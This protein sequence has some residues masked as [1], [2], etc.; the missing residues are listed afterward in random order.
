MPAVK[1]NRGHL[2]ITPCVQMCAVLR[3]LS[4]TD[5]RR[6]GRYKGDRRGRRVLAGKL[7]QL[8]KALGA[9]LC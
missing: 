7:N 9:R 2:D 4:D 3:M 8:V 5:P 6:S 1:N